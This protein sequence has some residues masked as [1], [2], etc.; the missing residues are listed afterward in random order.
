[1]YCAVKYLVKNWKTLT[2]LPAGQEFFF[3]ASM[4]RHLRDPLILFRRSLDL[5]FALN[6]KSVR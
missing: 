3:V 5:S 4:T 6:Y 2:I 1:M